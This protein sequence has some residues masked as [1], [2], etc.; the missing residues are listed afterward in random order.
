MLGRRHRNP[1]PSAVDSN[2]AKFSRILTYSL[3]GAALVIAIVVWL[4]PMPVDE[5]ALEAESEDLKNVASQP[6]ANTTTSDSALATA[7][8]TQFVPQMSPGSTIVLPEDES[9]F[10]VAQ[11]QDELRAVASQIVATYPDNFGAWHCA[12]QAFAELKQSTEAEEYWKRCLAM[13]PEFIGPYLGLAKLLMDK[14]RNEDAIEVLNRATELGGTDPELYQTL[15][16][17]YEN[18]GKL[19]E[20]SRAV[21]RGLVFYPNEASLHLVRARVATQLGDAQAA[22]ASI[23]KA[24]EFGGETEAALTSLATILIRQGKRDE[25]QEVRK[26]ISD[27]R[28]DP[29]AAGGSNTEGD[30]RFQDDYEFALRG[31]ARG[32]FASAASVYAANNNLSQA[33][34]L[35]LRALTL[36]PND[37]ETLLG[38]SSAL[39]HQNKLADLE[40][41]LERLISLN[42]DNIV[43][44]VNLA[45]TLV[46]LGEV[47]RAETTL[48]AAIER[49]PSEPLP[50][51][52]LSKLYLSTGRPVDARLAIVDVVQEVPSAATFELLAATYEASG[53][54]K[55]AQAAREKA[56]SFDAEIGQN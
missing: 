49:A 56:K 36:S 47:A 48:K 30:D 43:H 33:E 19:D 32:V 27:R 45:T 18:L 35:Y 3:A 12:A 1:S 40:I 44:R 42:P 25:A 23:R 54:Y 26:K 31:I 24:I 4:T 34:Q 55:A 7:T 11:L 2:A 37:N 20:A 22:E 15:G 52:A 39:L 46:Q 41:V 50:K 10:V 9:T 28:A 53:D 51:V 5:E 8:P 16:E 29:V 14:G 38:L 21:A 13:S 6:E 17:C